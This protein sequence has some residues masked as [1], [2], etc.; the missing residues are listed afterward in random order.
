M[1]SRLLGWLAADRTKRHPLPGLVVYY[2]TGG[3]PKACSIGNISSSGM[4]ICT[5]ERWL[6]GSVIP[7]TLQRVNAT[8]EEPEDWVA[9]L[10]QVVRSGPDGYGVAFVFSKSTNLF[11]DEMPQEKIADSEALKRFLRHLKLPDGHV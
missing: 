10:A 3:A 1:I 2:W 8:G 7:M 6:P 4:Y 11:G 5:D 9:V